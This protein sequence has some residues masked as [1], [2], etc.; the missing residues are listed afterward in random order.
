[1]FDLES[2]APSSRRRRN[3]LPT[4]ARPSPCRRARTHSPNSSGTRAPRDFR[5]AFQVPSAPVHRSVRLSHAGLVSSRFL[6]FLAGGHEV[7]LD[8]A[9]LER[10]L[11]GA[12]T[13][14]DHAPR[15]D[16]R[17]AC[18]AHLVPGG[19]AVAAGGGQGAAGQGLPG[20]GMGGEQF[21]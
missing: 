4:A 21:S 7:H 9:V 6:G 10:Q 2:G 14:C 19:E 11:G 18:A 13:V 20:L 1:M 15:G 3:G 5:S 12:A 16:A 17:R 8:S